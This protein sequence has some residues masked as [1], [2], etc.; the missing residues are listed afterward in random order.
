MKRSAT[1]QRRRKEQSERIAQLVALCRA[2][3]ANVT[4]HAYL[5]Q[6]RSLKERRA[7][8]HLRTAQR[9]QNLSALGGT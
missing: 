4:V 1:Q 5:A 6:L 7:T 2:S 9:K 3:Q 8:A